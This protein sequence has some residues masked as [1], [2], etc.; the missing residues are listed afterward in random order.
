MIVER[1]RADEGLQR[2]AALLALT[3]DNIIA[4]DM[5]R[6]MT[7]WNRGAEEMYGW[8]AAEVIGRVAHA[9]L[10]TQFPPPLEDRA[11]LLQGRRW[12]GEPVHTVRG[13]GRAPAQGHASCDIYRN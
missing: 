6:R 11:A 8:T 4:L 12:E 5:E 2:R 13:G 10:D 9:L 3:H 7:F 1:Q